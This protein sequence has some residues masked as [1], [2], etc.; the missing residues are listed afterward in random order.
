MIESLSSSLSLVDFERAKSVPQRRQRG[1]EEEKEE[2]GSLSLS[3]A[4]R[5]M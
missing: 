2:E 1:E 5:I 4:T 3:L